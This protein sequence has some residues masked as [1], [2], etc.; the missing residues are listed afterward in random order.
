MKKKKGKPKTK[1]IIEEKIPIPTQIADWAKEREKQLYVA[2]II[3]LILVGSG[4]WYKNY[5]KHKEWR[6]QKQYSIIVSTYP[7]DN[8]TDKTKWQT[9]IKKLE[10]FLHEFKGTKTSLAAQLDLANAFYHV[11]SYGRA[12][13]LYTELLDQIDSNHPYWQLS[14]FGLAYCYEGKKDYTKAISILEKVK[15]NPDTTM[16]ALV[17]YNLGRIYELTGKKS[18]A[19]EEYKKYLEKENFGIFKV[20]VE[21][22]VKVLEHKTVS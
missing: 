17:H 8:L 20:L 12:I 11:G 3:I 15:A 10:A 4:W 9:P 1:R 22:K 13:D 18:K 6:A 5:Q 7:T 21:E 19:L 16:M 2:A 14:Q